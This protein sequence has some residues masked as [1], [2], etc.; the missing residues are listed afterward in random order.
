[1]PS[2][3]QFNPLDPEVVSDPYPSYAAL[4]ANAPVFWHERMQSWLLTR[5]QDCRDVL[6]DHEVFARDW[7]RVGERIPDEALSVQLLD[8]PDILP[9]RRVFTNAFK[10]QDLEGM[11]RRGRARIAEAFDRQTR[12]SAFELMSQVAAPVAES[13]TCELFGVDRPPP[14]AFAEIAYGIALK[15]DAGLVPE[16]AAPGAAAAAK[17][18]ALVDSWFAAPRD[19]GMVADVARGA[20]A[21]EASDTM[22]HRTLAAMCNAA[23]STIYASIGNAAVVLLQHPEILPRLADPALLGTGVDELIRFDSPAQATSRV[24]TRTT[25]L[26]DT[27]VERGQVVVTLFGAANRDPAKFASPDELVLDRSPNPHLGFGWGSHS[28]LGAELARLV[29]REFVSCLRAWPARLE[30]AGPLQR[31]RT[32]TLRWLDSLPVTLS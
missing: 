2:K 30:L 22:V 4:R 31:R 23:Y 14:G 3:M 12:R 11:C 6:Q 19:P 10:A 24:A 17:L 18:V 27:T 15:M 32:A 16:Q 28:C 1:M 8:P 25:K 20:R 26:G 21:I 29:L 7:R 9:L 13:I 5:Y